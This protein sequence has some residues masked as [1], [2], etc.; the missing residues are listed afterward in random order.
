MRT[1]SSIRNAVPLG[2]RDLCLSHAAGD[3]RCT[4]AR[5]AHTAWPT[6]L[7]LPRAGELPAAGANVQENLRVLRLALHEWLRL[8][9]YGAERKSIRRF[10]NR[11]GMR[12]RL[13]TTSPPA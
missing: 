12:N 10:L 13:R 3:G 1:A 5:L 6:E 4:A 11:T 7:R 9:V 2:A 8:A